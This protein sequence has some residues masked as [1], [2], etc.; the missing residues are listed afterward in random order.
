MVRERDPQ[1]VDL[2][3]EAVT[4]HPAGIFGPRVSEVNEADCRVSRGGRRGVRA[5]SRARSL[6]AEAGRRPEAAQRLRRAAWR[7]VP[8]RPRQHAAPPDAGEP[9]STSAGVRSGVANERGAPRRRARARA[10]SGSDG[11]PSRRSM[12]RGFPVVGRMPLDVEQVVAHLEREPDVPAARCHGVDDRRRARR[13]GAP[14]CAPTANSDAVLRSDDLEVVR[15]R[16]RRVVAGSGPACTSPS[17]RLMHASA[18]QRITSASK[19]AQSAK[20]R[21]KR[22]SPAT[23][24]SARP[25]RC[26]ADGRPRRRLAAVDD[27]V[28]QQRGGVDQLERDARPR[29][30][31]RVARRTPVAAAWKTRSTTSRPDAL[32]ARTARGA[33]RSP[34]SRASRDVELGGEALLDRARGRRSTGASGMAAGSPRTG[35]CASGLSGR[36]AGLEFECRRAMSSDARVPLRVH[37]RSLGLR[38]MADPTPERVREALRAVLFPNFRRDIVTLGMVSDDVARRAGRRARAAC[39]PAPTSPRCAEQLVASSRGRV[40]ARARRHA[41]VD[42]H[43]ARRRGG[44]RTRSVRGRAPL[45]GRAPR[46]R[47]RRARRAASGSR[48][49]RST[50]RSRS[51][52]SGGASAS[53]MSTS[54]GRACRSCSASTRAR[55]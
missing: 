37:P 6:A 48:P 29:S 55:R 24:V 40:A 32:A 7:P 49:W 53:S 27:V 39:V 10:R 19:R 54:T 21:L 20:A 34:A 23:S 51:R 35:G 45:A 16:H 5:S 17:V 4:R 41:T 9:G 14:P 11:L 3:A 13:R 15:D 52:Q 36:A 2:A 43:S 12:P 42:V 22:K 26:S 44:T 31:R 47:G 1:V 28:V 30:R 25:K 46:D 38:V 8:R 18:A 50:W 33:P